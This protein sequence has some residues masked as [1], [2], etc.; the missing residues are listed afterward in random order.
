MKFYQELRKSVKLRYSDT[1]DH[2]EYEAKM[3]KLMDNYIS[4][5]EV[6]RITNPVD[7]L[8]E[9]QFEEEIERL[10]SK[11]AK[12]DAI[13]TRLTKSVNTKWDENPAYYKRFSERIKKRFKLIRNSEFLRRSI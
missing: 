8:N 7:I 12:A 9:K 2:K 3:Q 11:R 5:E 10:G 4:A 13:R 6:I 1:I